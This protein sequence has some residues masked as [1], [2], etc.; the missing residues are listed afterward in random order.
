MKKLFLS[1]LVMLFFAISIL[2]FDIS[3]KKETVAT[4]ATNNNN[5]QTGITQQNK[6]IYKKIVY[7]TGLSSSV[8]TVWIC[9][10][11]GTNQ[12][13]VP[14]NV[15]TG[16][17]LGTV[18]ITPDG[19]TIVYNTYLS[20]TTTTPYTLT[21]NMYSCNVDGSGVV[22]IVGNST[23]NTYYYPNIAY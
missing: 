17:T 16:Y 22:Q 1:S 20:Q 4:P 9:N 3:C 5:N 6:V 7:S 10:L 14:I 18:V 21:G 19:K 23:T 2:I 15:P 12:Q 13:Q 11:D 8:T